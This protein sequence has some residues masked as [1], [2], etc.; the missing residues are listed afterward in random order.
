MNNFYNINIPL[1]MDRYGTDWDDFK[2]VTGDNTDHL[3][4][5]TYQLYWLADPNY[6]TIRVAEEVSKTLDLYYDASTTLA[7]MKYNIRKFLTTYANKGLADTYLDIQENIVGVRGV[8]YTGSDIGWQ[9]HTTIVNNSNRWGSTSGTFPGA[10]KWSVA[11]PQFFIYIDVKTT[12]STLLDQIQ[13]EYRRDEML[14][15]FYQIYL[16]DSSFNLLRTI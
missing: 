12:N 16:I 15:A 8:I 6:F 11:P 3:M 7:T 10:F 2:T 4:N 5:K 13:E 1:F 9:N 14:P